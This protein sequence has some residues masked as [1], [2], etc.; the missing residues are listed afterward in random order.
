MPMPDITA[1][2]TGHVLVVD[3]ENMTD[4]ERLREAFELSQGLPDDEHHVYVVQGDYSLTRAEMFHSGI[5]QYDL[6]VG[7]HYEMNSHD[8]WD[9][10]EC[11]AFGHVA[12]RDDTLVAIDLV[13]DDIREEPRYF[14]V[15]GEWGMGC[16][17]GRVNTGYAEPLGALEALADT[18]DI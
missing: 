18:Y 13:T 7:P 15:D 6:A 11:E 2:D 17:V 8:G 3:D 16:E 14:A 4:S 1:I 12:Y 9:V 5:F 10:S